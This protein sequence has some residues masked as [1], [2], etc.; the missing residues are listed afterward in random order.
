M[1][2]T[3]RGSRL[4][5]C[6]AKSPALPMTGPE[7]EWKLTPSSRATICASVVLPRPGGPTNSTWSSASPRDLADWMK[8]PRFL[9]A[10]S[11]PAKS[12]RSCGR[13]AVS[14]S[15]R[16]SAEISRRDASAP[17]AAFAR[18]MKPIRQGQL[19][20]HRQADEVCGECADKTRNCSASDESMAKRDA[21]PA[22]KRPV[23]GVRA[24]VGLD[25][26]F[27]RGA[28]RVHAR[29]EAIDNQSAN[30]SGY[31][32]ARRALGGGGVPQRIKKPGRR[33]RPGADNICRDQSEGVP[34]QRGD[35]NH[36]PDRLG[37]GRRFENDGKGNE[38]R[39]PDGRPER[40]EQQHDA[41]HG[42]KEGPPAHCDS[43]AT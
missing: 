27:D 34:K 1:N 16:F 17:S 5:S 30:E 8:T 26:H 39:A 38:Q 28:H 13:I 22:W 6:P 18:G 3:S 11:C 32:R 20:S 10:A 29:Q 36:K 40:R 37:I 24:E 25:R 35:Q 4:V 21:E 31:K 23:S 14:S 19:R 12:A 33:G 15:G 43:L 9:R 41:D 2:S 42:D 7:V